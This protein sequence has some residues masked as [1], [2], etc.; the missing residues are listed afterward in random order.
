MNNGVPYVQYGYPLDPSNSVH[1]VLEFY[2]PSR[3][4]FS[5]SL[6]VVAYMPTNLFVTGI[7]NRVAVST[8]FEDK[9][10]NPP[11]M[12]IEWAST[13]GKTYLVI[14]S[15]QVN[16]T[17]WNVATPS[18]T[19]TANITQWYDDGPPKTS[20]EPLTA[21]SRFYVIIQY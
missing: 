9:R 3:L 20:S 10:T 11:R 13:P 14:Y 16:P 8:F 6:F 21:N 4:P 19:A 5:N 2:D 7:S 17:S 1:F 15:D 12:V 18:I